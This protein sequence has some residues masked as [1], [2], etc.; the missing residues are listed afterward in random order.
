MPDLSTMGVSPE[1]QLLAV[2]IAAAGGGFGIT[3][4]AL[5]D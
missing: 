3:V 4:L 1:A 5:Q 2:Q